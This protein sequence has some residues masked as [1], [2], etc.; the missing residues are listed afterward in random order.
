MDQESHGASPMGSEARDRRTWQKRLLP[1]MVKMVIGLTGFFF[2]ASFVQLFYLQHHLATSTGIDL[3]SALPAIDSNVT[4]DSSKLDAVRW[5]NLVALE[6]YSLQR[7]Y[8]QA[9]VLLMARVWTRYLGFVTGM[10]CTL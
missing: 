9:N 10:I 7:R 4:V 5:T 1:V 8:H 3:K 2:G 6:Q